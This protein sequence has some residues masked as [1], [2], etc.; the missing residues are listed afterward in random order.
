[1]TNRLHDFPP[2]TPDILGCKKSQTG[3]ILAFGKHFLDN[4]FLLAFGTKGHF[5]FRKV[6]DLGMFA[7]GANNFHG[8]TLVSIFEKI[9]DVLAEKKAF[10]TLKGKNTRKK[11]GG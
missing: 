8:L 7:D 9:H 6:D 3:S 5:F 1:M 2:G 11:K 10:Y 4:H